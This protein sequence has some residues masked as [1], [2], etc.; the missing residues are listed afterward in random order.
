VNK[1][2]DVTQ[3]YGIRCI[4]NFCITYITGTGTQLRYIQYR[5][6]HIWSDLQFVS[7]GRVPWSGLSPGE[8]AGEMRRGIGLQSAPPLPPHEAWPIHHQHQQGPAAGPTGDQG[9]APIH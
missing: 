6:H 2:A 1:V 7:Q 3:F 8:V 9:H 5:Y 4:P